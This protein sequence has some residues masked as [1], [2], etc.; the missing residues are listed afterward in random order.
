MFFPTATLNIFPTSSVI[1]GKTSCEMGSLTIPC[2][3]GAKAT[4]CQTHAAAWGHPQP[5]SPHP[6][7]RS[8]PVPSHSNLNTPRTFFPPSSFSFHHYLLRNL[9]PIS[10]PFSSILSKANQTNFKS[11]IW[12]DTISNALLNPNILGFPCS[13]QPLILRFH[14]KRKSN[15]V[16]LARFI[17][18]KSPL[19]LLML[20][21][22]SGASLS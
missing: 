9:Q 5:P 14:Q 10:P 17:L 20:S 8:T 15:Q 1:A 18:P 6:Q 16:C 22:S 4:R 3:T 21:L 19:L 12:Q 11:K 7:Q 13:A 2:C